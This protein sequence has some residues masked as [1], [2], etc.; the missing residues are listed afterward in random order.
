MGAGHAAVAG[1]STMHT[2]AWL[3]VQARVLRRAADRSAVA[4]RRDDASGI[5]AVTDAD[6]EGAR[7]FAASA[8]R[9]RLQEAEQRR[10]AN[11]MDLLMR[12]IEIA[13]DGHLARAAAAHVG[14]DRDAV[15]GG[16][17]AAARLDRLPP[18]DDP[19]DTADDLGDAD[20][21]EF[22]P[23]AR[24]GARSGRGSNFPSGGGKAGHPC[25]RAPGRP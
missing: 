1:Q 3:R 22:H 18:P 4:A 7:R 23:A 2:M 24:S 13:R 8:E 5:R 25:L 20:A 16:L 12:E 9:A 21:A 19:V 11:R 10:T 15:V 14:P 17:E 6:A